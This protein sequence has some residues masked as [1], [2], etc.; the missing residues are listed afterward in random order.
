[1]AQP[2]P[3]MA[4]ERHRLSFCPVP[5]EPEGPDDVWLGRRRCGIHAMDG[6]DQAQTSMINVAIGCPGGEPPVDLNGGLAT[7]EQTIFFG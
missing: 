5:R 7:N 6:C 4:L 1:M 3:G 2:P